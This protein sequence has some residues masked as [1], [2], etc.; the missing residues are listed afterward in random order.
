MDI[1]THPPPC[2]YPLVVVSEENKNLQSFIQGFTLSGATPPPCR[3]SGR[4]STARRRRR[5][6]DERTARREASHRHQTSTGTS[7]RRTA[8]ETSLATARREVVRA[9]RRRSRA[10]LAARLRSPQ[11]ACWYAAAFG[12]RTAPPSFCLWLTR[13]RRWRRTTQSRLRP[14]RR[15][16]A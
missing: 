4:V 13:R 7:S 2:N 8:L 14:T 1:T 12:V 10:L 5:G 3:C 9:L 6:P 16:T 15:R 11:T